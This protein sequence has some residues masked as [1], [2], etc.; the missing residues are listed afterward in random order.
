MR[1]VPPRTQRWTGFILA[2]LVAVHAAQLGLG[3]GDSVAILTRL[4][5][6]RPDRVVDEGEVWRVATGPWLHGGLLHLGLNGVALV[7]L[8]GL[9]ERIHGPRRMWMAYVACGLVGGLGTMTF[10][11]GQAVTGV[12]ASGAI[13]GLAGLVLGNTWYGE[14]GLQQR[15]RR[16]LGETLTMS[17]LVTFALGALTQAAWPVVDNG[18]HLFGFGAGL[19]LATVWR[20]PSKRPQSLTGVWAAAAV[21]MIAA[22]MAARDGGV[23]L[24]TL[25]RDLGAWQAE[26]A[27]EQG[28]WLGA[29]SGMAAVDRLVAAGQRADAE[30]LVHELAEKVE[31][32]LEVSVLASALIASHGDD[33]PGL[34]RVAERWV[35]LSPDD[36]VAHNL[37]A[38]RLLM[39][40]DRSQDP[41]AVALVK[42]ALSLLPLDA[43]P[44][45]RGTML[46]TYGLG[47][48]RTGRQADAVAALREA[49]DL[50][51]AA[52]LDEEAEVAERY[53]AVLAGDI[54]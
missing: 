1:A 16:N 54:P 19:A 18:A 28:G 26:R 20:G 42:R 50:V 10:F 29:M 31:D 37:L 48:A 8:G 21:P 38:W 30:V 9:V 46:D 45:L 51:R 2:V 36:A 3:D 49:L 22:L 5:A 34:L 39:G 14:R 6:L 52:G 27:R 44:G 32:P 35:A 17:V 13:L 11:Y 47:L 24:T 7:Q 25:D 12:G 33:A 15:L 53:E 40:P 41:R 23:A 4:G 43:D